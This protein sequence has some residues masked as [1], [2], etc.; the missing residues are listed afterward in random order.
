MAEDGERSSLSWRTEMVASLRRAGAIHSAEIA[1]AFLAVPRERFVP[2]IAARDGLAAIYAPDTALATATDARGV[3]ISSSSAP[4][5]MAPMLEALELAP[6]LRVLEV[7]AGTG[8]NAAILKTLV[9]AD[10]RVTSIDVEPAFARRARQALRDGGHRCSV[11]VGDGELGWPTGAPFDRIIVTASAGRLPR[12]WRDQLIGGGL[13]E[14]PLRLTPDTPFQAIVTLRRDADLLRS[15]SIIAGRFMPL[16]QPGDRGGGP[17]SDPSLYAR[18]A[19]SPVPF[20][21]IGG[22]CL[23][24]LSKSAGRSTLAALLGPSRVGASITRTST[25]GLLLFLALSGAARLVSVTVD[26]RYGIGVVDPSGPSVSAVSRRPGGGG[27]IETWGDDRAQPA[28]AAQV[29]N[30]EALGC[31][32]LRELRVTVRYDGE[33]GPTTW[34]RIELDDSVVSLDWAHP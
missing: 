12:A 33:R 20:A 17:T 24:S 22:R 14:V 19:S 4:A 21:S 29:A 25:G 30:W 23:A 27:R 34:R 15:T 9:G 5:I 1:D 7:G 3:P 2:E 11:V 8:Y 18:T 32:T 13:V 26:G 31:P 16:R 6:G 10:G 28:L